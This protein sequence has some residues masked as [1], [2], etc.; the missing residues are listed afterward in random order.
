VYATGNILLAY[1]LGAGIGVLAGLLSSAVLTKVREAA[2]AITSWMIAE[3]FRVI[4][5]NNEYVGGSQGLSVPLTF[6]FSKQ[7]YLII[8]ALL[9]LMI[10]VG[11]FLFLSSK[12]GWAVKSMMYDEAG[13]ERMGISTLNLRIIIIALSGLMTGILGAFF[14][15][16]NLYIDPETAFSFIWM[17]DILT[18]VILGG[19]GNI[20]GP[21]IGAIPFLF[22]LL[23][24]R[25]QLGELNI[26][27]VGV[28]L[29][30]LSIFF[31][32]GIAGYGKFML[33]KVF[34]K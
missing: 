24:L 32:K 3:I 2:F 17:I 22:I 13:T 23:Y 28:F 31:R 15:H 5:H 33:Q 20:F 8:I 25:L 11:I 26:L 29:L 7:A 19:V 1:I 30:V 34:K 14:A 21:V 9:A 27:F 12:M 18:I 4:F 16:Y 10:N 6:A